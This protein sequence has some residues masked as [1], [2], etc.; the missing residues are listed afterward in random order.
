MGGRVRCLS[1]SSQTEARRKTA[2][3][4]AE[5]DK[6]IYARDPA[7]HG[8]GEVVKEGTF[9]A[10]RAI[11]TLNPSGEPIRKSHRLVG[12]FL[13]DDGNEYT[14]ED[15]D[16]VMLSDFD[17]DTD[18]H[19]KLSIVAKDYG[20]VQREEQFQI[21]DAVIGMI[22]G[23]HY[24]SAVNLRDGK[25][26]VLTAYLGD[27]VLDPNGRADRNKRFLWIFNSWD[28]SWAFRFKFG[29]F[30]VEC[31]NMAAMALRGSTDQNVLGTDWSTRH[32]TNIMDRVEEASKFLG[33]WKAHEKLFEAQANHM[34]QTELHP[35]AFGRIIEGLYQTKNKTTNQMEVDRKTAEAVRVT[36][37][38]SA[39][40]K[41]I[42]DT[43]WGG[44]NAV[45]EHHDWVTV[46]RGSKNTSIDEMRFVK[47]IE[48]PTGLKQRAWD[49][50][51]NHARDVKEFKMPDLAEA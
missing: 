32:T 33:L 39:S 22:G 7:W 10:A 2:I 44:F 19:R 26:T 16:D 20:L 38:L 37:E 50:F 6:A 21:A 3:M 47:Q 40:S 30:R 51:W 17:S 25:Q 34:I 29:D 48:D 12:Y 28:R 11:A 43:V 27:Y 49:A 42:H 31:A 9:T 35:N 13:D 18:A 5:V 4:P 23:A 1:A 24:E 46:P 36:Y 41:D 8:L 15:I 14:V 45:T